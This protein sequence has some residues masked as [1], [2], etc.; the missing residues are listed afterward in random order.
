MQHAVP[1]IRSVGWSV[2]QPRGLLARRRAS[3]ESMTVNALPASINGHRGHSLTTRA[4]TDQPAR[5][6][7]C[8]QS[9]FVAQQLLKPHISATHERASACL[10][11]ISA[12]Q[13][14]D[15]AV[16]PSTALGPSRCYII[17]STTLSVVTTTI[18]RLLLLHST[19]RC[20][21]F[22]SILSIYDDLTENMNTKYHR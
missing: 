3:G 7:I 9:V 2:G 10:L 8:S 13:S 22:I 1:L 18:C 16:R 17:Q 6:S 14:C 19:Q 4:H 12:H 21:V 20:S 5:S 11:T 15:A